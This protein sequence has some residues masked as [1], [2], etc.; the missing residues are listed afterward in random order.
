M[1]RDLRPRGLPGTFTFE[2]KLEKEDEIL[3]GL[4]TALARNQLPPEVWFKLH[5]AAA[6]DDRL[7]ELAFSYEAVSQGKRLKTQTQPVVAEFLYRASTFFSDT[8][9]DELGAVSYL[10]RA[11]AAQPAHLAAFERLAAIYTKAKKGKAL[12]DLAASVASHR[13][14]AEQL[15][16]LKRAGELYTA[17]PASDEKATEIYQQLVRLDPHDE[18]TR[19]A[20]EARL[21]KANRHRDVARFA[22]QALAT[23]P[24]P[25]EAYAREVRARLIELY[26]SQLHEPERSMPHVEA[27]LLADPSHDEARRVALKLLEVKGLAA[28]AAAALAS[29]CEQAGVPQ[30]VARFLAIELEHTRGPKRRDVLRKIGFLRQDKLLDLEG[31]FDVFEQVL[32]LDPTDEEVRRRFVDLASVLH[33]ELVA[34][35]TLSRVGTGVKDPGLKAHLAAELGKL[36]LAGGDGKRARATFVGVLALP[37]LEPALNLVAARALCSIY[38]AEGDHKSLADAL[39]RVALLEPDEQL[40]Q[41]ANFEL[42]EL[43]TSALH[44][45]ARAIAAWRRLAGTTLRA[46]ALEALEHLY[47][48]AGDA[49][50]LADVLEERAKDTES[51]DEARL[52]AF[53]AAEV[54]TT[55]TSDSAK[56]SAAWRRVTDKFGAARD[57]HARWLP[58]LESRRQW[59]ELA[60]ALDAEATLAPEGERVALYVKLGVVR[61]QKTRDLPGAVEAFRRALAVEPTEKTSRSALEKLLTSGDQRIAAADVLEPIYRSER[62]IAGMLRVLEIKGT[63]ADTA[64]VRLRALEEASTLAE[65]SPQDQSK[66]IDWVARGLAEAVTSREPLGSWLERVDRLAPATSDPKRR[67]TVLASAMDGREIDSAERLHLAKKTAEAL[68][69]AGLVSQAL[70]QYRRALAFEP[71]ST[72]LLSQVDDLLR[73]QG[74][75]VERVQLYRAALERDPTPERR[76]QLLHKI[77]AIQRSDVGDSAGAIETYA[78]A[79]ANDPDDGEARATLAA[80]YTETEAWDLLSTLLEEQLARAPQ[81]EAKGVRARIAELASVHGQPNRARAHARQLL[82]EGSL[83]NEDLDS[84]ERVAG[85]LA[86]A[87]LLRQVLERRADLAEDPREEVDW[88]EKLGALAL[89]RGAQDEAVTVWKRA[90]QIAQKSGDEDTT[91]RLYES[92]R[93]VA[94]HDGDAA[95]HLA[96]LLE[97]AEKWDR[98]PELY[99]ILLDH[100]QL[101]SARISILMRHARVLADKMDDAA[102]A[103]VSAAQAFEL[104][105]DSSEYREVLSTFTAL[106]LQGKATHIFAQAMDDAIVRHA[107]DSPEKGAQRADLRMAKARVLSANRDGRD[108]ASAAYRATLDDRSVDDGRLKAALLAFEMLL[109]REPADAWLEDRRWLL[110][111]KAEHSPEGERMSALLAWASAEEL[112]FGDQTRAL[113]LYRRVEELDPESAEVLAAISRLALSTGD[114]PG[115]LAALSARRERS[116]GST[117]SALDLEIATIL[118]YRTDRVEEALAP[119][120]SVLS[121]T[122]HDEAALALAAQLLAFPKTHT[123]AIAIL[124]RAE[125][126]AE[127][128]SQKTT[129]LQHLLDSRSDPPDPGEL[130]RGWYERLLDAY[131]AE[132]RVDLALGTALTAVEELPIV[133]SLLDR[134][135]ELARELGRPAEIADLYHRTLAQPLPI[136]SV[137]NLGRRAV[138]FHEEWFEDS[139]GVVKILERVLQ[140]DGGARWAFDRLKLLFDAAERWE[141]LFA[142]FDRAAAVADDTRKAELYEDAA[143]IAKDFANNPD[144]AIDYL[145]KLLPLKPQNPRLVASLERLYERRGAHRELIALL[146]SQLASQTDDE[147]EGARARIARLWLYEIGDAASALVVVEEMLPGLVDTPRR[148]P[149]DAFLFELLEKILAIALPHVESHASMPPAMEGERGRR[150]SAPF[151][152]SGKRMPVRLRAAALLKKLY[153]D[154]HRDADLVRILEIELE[155]IKSVKEL[156]RRHRQIAEMYQKL[157]KDAEASEHLASLVLLEPDVVRH[158]A[159]LGELAARIG[160]YDRLADTLERAAEDTTD[161]ALKVELLMQAG[162]EHVTHLADTG[163]AI[164]L[165]LRVLGLPNVAK[166]LALAAARRVDPLLEAADRARARLDVNEQIALLET[167]PEAKAEAFIAAAR[168]AAELGENARAIASLEARLR[169]ADDPDALDALVD[170]LHR[171]GRWRDLVGVLEKRARSGPTDEEKRRDLVRIAHIERDELRNADAAISAW[172][173]VGVQFGQTN[174]GTNALTSL[175]EG[176]ERWGELALLLERAAADAELPTQ[177]AEWLGKLGDVRRTRLG[178]LDGAIRSYEGALAADPK[179]E[180]AR[181]G[182]FELLLDQV[183]RA[184]AVEALRRAYAETSEWQ[185][186]LSLTEHRLASASDGAGGYLEESKARVRILREAAGL[187]ED[188]GHDRETAFG[189]LAR[190]FLETPEDPTIESEL[191]RLAAATGLWRLAAEAYATAIDRAGGAPSDGSGGREDCAWVGPVRYRLGEILETHLDD[192][193]HALDVYVRSA[194]DAP[195]DPIIARAVIRVAAR[196]RRWS[197]VAQ[198][199]VTASRAANQVTDDLPLAVEEFVQGQEAWDGVARALSATLEQAADLP[200]FVARDLEARLGTW[201]SDR[202]SDPDS[203]EAAFTQ[204]LAKD[205]ENRELLS[206]VAQLQRRARGRPLIDSLLRLSRATGGDLELLREAAETAMT[207][208]KDRG[209]AKSIL[210]SLRGQAVEQWVPGFLSRSGRE[211]DPPAGLAATVVTVGAPVPPA[212]LAEWSMRELV[213]IYEEEHNPQGMLDLLVETAKLPFDAAVSRAMLHEAARIARNR[214]EDPERAIELYGALFEGNTDDEEAISPLIEL[215]ERLGKKTELFLLYC[216]RIKDATSPERRIELRLAAANIQRSIGDVDGAVQTLGENLAEAPRHAETSRALASTLEETGR[217]AELVDLL[218]SQARLALLAGEN[219]EAANACERAARLAEERLADQSRAVHFYERV[220]ELEERPA[221]LDALARLLAGRGEH[222]RAADILERLCRTSP[223]QRAALGLRLADALSASGRPDV[224]RARIEEAIKE[225]PDDEPLRARLSGIYEK[226][227][228]WEPLANLLAGGASHA[229]NKATRL[230]RLLRSAELFTIRCARPEAAIPLLEQASDLDP[231]DRGIRLAL[232]DALGATGR[233]AEARTMLRAIID[234]FGGRRPKER[235]PAHYHLA[236]LELKMGDRARALV[237]L[238]AATRI[239][240]TNPGILRTLAELARDDGQLDRA[241]RSYRALLVALPRA[242]DS[243]N[244]APIVRA[245]VLLELSTVAE[246]QGE[247]DRSRE[248]LESALESAAKSDAEGDRFERALRLRADY[249]TLVRALEARVARTEGSPG[250][251]A[252]LSDLA[253]VLDVHLGQWARA[254]VT[255]LR[256]LTLTPISAA[257]H[258]SAL[259]LARRTDALPRYV[260]EVERLGDEA[261]RRGDVAQAGDLFVQLGKV[262]ETEIKDDVRAAHTYE[263]AERLHPLPSEPSPPDPSAQKQELTILRALDRVYERLGDAD[264]QKRVLLRRAQVESKDDDPNAAADALY[265]LAALLLASRE[266]ADTGAELLERALLSAPDANRAE[267]ILETAL[268]AYPRDE[269][270]VG[271]FERV[272]R[273]PGHERTLIEALALRSELEGGS[274]DPIREAV[275]VSRQIANPALTESLLRGFVA[276]NPIDGSSPGAEWALVELA[277]MRESLGDVAEAIELKQRAAQIAHPED[278]RRLRFESARL[279]SRALGN[280]EL[281]AELYEALLAEDPAD[282]EAWEPLLDVY[283]RLARTEKLAALLGKVVDYVE[284]PAQ[285]SKLRLHRVRVMMKHHGL[286]DDAAPLLRD[287]VDEDPGQVEAA[288]LLAGILERQGNID[289]LARLLARQLDTAKDRQDSASVGSLALRLGQLLETKDPLEAKNVL[290]AGLDWVGEHKEI[291]EVLTRIHGGDSPADRADLLER[292]LALTHGE[293]AERQALEAHEL[294]KMERDEEG[295]E[296]ALE[297]GFRANPSSATLG[298]RLE[299]VY[300]ERGAWEK[301]AELFVLDARG[302]THGPD[303]VRRLSEAAAILRSELHEPAKAA[304]LLIE[305]QRDLPEFPLPL[306]DDLIQT[307]SEAERYPEAIAQVTTALEGH[308]TD[309]AQRLRLLCKRASLRVKLEDDAGALADLEEASILVS[310]DLAPVIADKLEELRIRAAQRGDDAT[311]RTLRLRLA[312]ILPRAGNPEGGRAHLLDLIKRDAKDREALRGLARID[313][314]AERWDAAIAT[315]RRLVALEEGDAV[316]EIA[317]KLADACER[318][319]RLPDARG[320][321]ER[322]RLVAPHDEALHERLVRLYEH[323]GAHKE[324]AEMSLRDA[325]QARDVAGRFAHLVRAGALLSRHAIDPGAAIAAL[326]EAHALRPADVECIVL[327]AD[328]YTA[329]GRTADSVELLNVAIASHKGR[330][331][332]ELAALYHRLARAAH[333]MGERS[334]ELTW[335]A[336]ALDMDAQNGLVAAELASVALE[337]RHL[338]LATRALRA[339]TLLKEP[340]SSSLSKAVAYQKLGEIAREQGDVKRAVLLLK[341]AIDDDPTLASAR[342]LLDALHVE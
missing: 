331:S 115:A 174:E 257:A 74:S 72:E 77:G 307:L 229:P 300:R 302:R 296:R 219:D 120:E 42:A 106:A 56:A 126:A 197:V 322:A 175:L 209:L 210:E 304:A 193:E 135:E 90:A 104:A 30:D 287:I 184:S 332:R 122:P 275:F 163:R 298:A 306:F 95:F 33:K 158:R 130:R 273:S 231:S 152:K 270:L 68:A 235:A 150:D 138:A 12:A 51:P 326:E 94:P 290:Y 321:L 243:Q 337:E 205:T 281:S 284:D 131:S 240:P 245:E 292:L 132:G 301:L 262:I 214:L 293:D 4:L 148:P 45:P 267:A 144:R 111:W 169:M 63:L 265:R 239:D 19:D 259:A 253:E 242:E 114:M 176:T 100:T 177:R 125:A 70:A 222:A 24:P 227:E 233:L 168:L 194:A 178:E 295:A 79:L 246:R 200:Q 44:D 8:F 170:L 36:Y 311:E 105:S 266:T 234:G 339:I 31:A 149:R 221:S 335:L 59:P 67:A 294:R 277:A 28:R 66:A 201:H 112:T 305:A 41:T 85:A 223:E 80:L 258:E 272:G 75:P 161:P 330:R 21:R 98:L 206:K 325:E 241:E 61:L 188:R 244:E 123:R 299:Q 107:G 328:V 162:D 23:D 202:R 192:A 154:A 254:F 261:E 139:A 146:S 167:D 232:A 136:E 48:A 101:P 247:V 26:A 43:A 53:R 89:S 213:R 274:A 226:T 103:L 199:L 182:A 109:S 310:D 108:A 190:A 128:P 47:D 329:A 27:L 82:E 147:A 9:G 92:V 22:E 87:T 78:T 249:V 121:S 315:Y 110:S 189:F 340:A 13:P 25:R 38:A 334:N 49:I 55:R 283:Q 18:G 173:Q 303:R 171:E 309:A 183:H 319:E 64:A 211:A 195:K 129:I 333:S 179:N 260:E 96:D 143:Q 236:R 164:D 140:I 220:I 271:L 286:G 323:T 279:A 181:A 46:R 217:I 2:S 84:L 81:E 11:L 336:S 34:A 291:L 159:E 248:I 269:R 297:A 238:D 187:A 29:A 93:G 342:V 276:R 118:L 212:P 52:L 17:D 308:T 117:R 60:T 145:E 215:Y 180:P 191:T 268:G 151:V 65:A 264:A 102:S 318:A 73:E 224:A 97:R 37:D 314:E 88:L 317:L 208:V 338:D 320:A 341:R 156:V 141:D 218:S 312:A 124:E 157:G 127:E 5:A 166:E 91:R 196:T 251:A 207:T 40:R 327:L 282:R 316:V 252:T 71:S 278:A 230:D 16:L 313:G 10:E 228:A 99:S 186:T 86:D 76:R 62:N 32:A 288:L 58:L 57:V 3:E 20:L 153:S 39:E 7:S 119:V 250:A 54:L 172:R 280:L 324:L 237:E 133:D 15:E 203:A 113:A 263:R 1:Q 204:A 285:R 35:Q 256:V 83:S 165:F 216:R 198:T 142:L 225:Y 6:R 255:R 137:L 289:E 14:K 69:V 155:A 50:E 134:A 185:L 116:E 160:R